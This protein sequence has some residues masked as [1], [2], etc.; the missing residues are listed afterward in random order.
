MRT[1]LRKDMVDPNMMKSKTLS[2]D[3]SR[4]I[5]YI[6]RADPRRTKL[7]TERLEPRFTKSKTDRLDPMRTIP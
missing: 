5:P 7:R 1:K 4:F 6:D 2:E 3:P